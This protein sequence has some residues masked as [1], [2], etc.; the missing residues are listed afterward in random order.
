[1]TGPALTELC[2]ILDYQ[3]RQ[4]DRLEEALTHP[5]V[6][7]RRVGGRSYQRLEFLGDR[8][9]GLVIA[10]LL[11]RRFPNAAEGDLAVRLNALVR[12]ET[13]ADVAVQVGLGRF[14]RLGRSESEQGGEAKPA[15]LADVCEAIIGA[16][17]LDGG[18]T[19]AAAFVETN[20]QSVMDERA[21]GR[22]DPKT[23]LQEA[24][25]ATAQEPPQYAVVDRAGPDHAPRFTVEVS[26]GGLPSVRGEG[27]SR[28]DAEQ[29]A[30][31]AMLRKLPRQG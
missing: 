11:L 24:V 12:R 17:Y 13:V 31:K 25:Q 3:F 26:V 18:L 30:A 23:R 28:R 2:D 20:W 1:M 22:K 19:A 27:G 10:D 7:A 6:D 15:I 9:L 4:P 21:L 8:V 29:A 14:I 5:S 16:L